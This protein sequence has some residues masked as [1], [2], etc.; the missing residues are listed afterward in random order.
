MEKIARGNIMRHIKY[1]KN[2]LLSDE[3]YGLRPGRSR[4]TVPKI[5]EGLS[6]DP[7]YLNLA[8]AFDKV[9]PKRLI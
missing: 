7:A 1:N 5:E 6:L 2:N 8:K 4:A 3:Q 9:S